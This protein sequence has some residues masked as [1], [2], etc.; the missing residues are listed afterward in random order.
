M[1]RITVKQLRASFAQPEIEKSTA[2][3]RIS[4]FALRP[5]RRRHLSRYGASGAR[6][7]RAGA[8]PFVSK[9]F[10]ISRFIRVRADSFPK[11][12]SERHHVDSVRP[13]SMPK[14]RRTG[15]VR[16]NRVTSWTIPFRLLSKQHTLFG[17][18]SPRT[19]PDAYVSTL[20]YFGQYD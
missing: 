20:G 10:P 13:C 16:R 1:D 3:G 9:Q 5:C 6:R 18:H 8:C 2:P 19:Q 12:N 17:K 11:P 15:R 4:A 14:A 7:R